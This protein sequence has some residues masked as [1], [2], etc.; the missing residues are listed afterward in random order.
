MPPI[1][2]L[3]K[4]RKTQIIDAA[5]RRIA[6][7]GCANVKMDDIVAESG[8]S[9]GGIA[10]YFPSKD[11]LFR[12]A[13]E[14]Y[15]DRVFD[16]VREIWESRTTPLERLLGLEA[17]FDDSREEVT[18]AYPILLD[19]MAMS[20][21]NDD[22]RRIF[23]RWV[24]R[25]VGMLEAAVLEAMDEGVLVRGD[26]REMARSISAIYQGIATRWYL[27]DEHHTAA[28]AEKAARDAVKGFLSMHKT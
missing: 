27:G 12:T 9:K 14:S 15:F 11:T 13:F 19:F 1:P 4:I 26:A 22:Y 28:W 2:E 5:I 23:Q 3:E 6:S 16:I 17:L 10:H 7:R 18:L 24:D 25:W 21:H 20:V 8:L